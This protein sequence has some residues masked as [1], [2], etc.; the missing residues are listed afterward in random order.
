MVDA[1]LRVLPL[2]SLSMQ[3]LRFPS[4]VH[5]E[6][7]G[8]GDADG[9]VVRTLASQVIASLL[10]E[11]RGVVGQSASD[12]H[13]IA[14]HCI[15]LHCIA[16]HC[17]ALHCI[18]LHCIALHCIALH[19]IALHCITDTPTHTHTHRP[20]PNHSHQHSYK[21]GQ[22]QSRH[23]DLDST[24]HIKAKHTWRTA[25]THSLPSPHPHYQAQTGCA[26][27]LFGDRSVE[28]SS[29]HDAAWRPR[30]RV[31]EKTATPALMVET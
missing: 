13:T 12:R 9:Q 5:I 6:D 29:R 4:L 19:C 1:L 26:L 7:E 8:L 25:A 18:A 11:V 16:L 24:G 20:L 10:G 14:L 22:R 28:P 3:S 21:R 15:A 30:L 31:A 17:I 23:R 27:L 2:Q